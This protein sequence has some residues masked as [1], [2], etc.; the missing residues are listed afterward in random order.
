MK[1]FQKHDQDKPD[2]HLLPVEALV[3]AAEVM[4]YGAKKY[5]A[6][7]WRKATTWNRYY[8]AAMRHLFAWQS[9]EDNDQESGFA[10]IDHAVC[11]LLML[12]SLSQTKT[13]EDDRY[14]ASRAYCDPSC[15]P[16]NRCGPEWCEGAA[17]APQPV[18]PGWEPTKGERVAVK[19]AGPFRV[20]NEA[21][22]RINDGK[23]D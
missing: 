13:G 20:I 18:P 22:K 9:G 8:D 15:V 10:H 2:M 21:F 5:S 19:G 1:G 17:R 6:H 7:N 4:T 11:C 12:S 14:K 23:W 16:E 3:A